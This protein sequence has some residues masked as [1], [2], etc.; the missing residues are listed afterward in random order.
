MAGRDRAQRAALFAAE[1]PVEDLADNRGAEDAAVPLR[2]QAFEQPLGRAG[3]ILGQWR[4]IDALNQPGGLIRVFDLHQQLAQR[5]RIDLDRNGQQRFFRRGD[6]LAFERQRNRQ[7]QVVVGVVAERLFTEKDPLP[8]LADDDDARL[9]DDGHA[10]HALAGPEKAHRV[11]VGGGVPFADGQGLEQVGE[12]S[13]LGDLH[14]PCPLMIGRI[15]RSGMSF[16]KIL[17][18]N[19]TNRQKQ[20]N[21]GQE[22]VLAHPLGPPNMKRSGHGWR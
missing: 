11:E 5:G 15:I 14:G 18:E 6:G 22:W 4:R 9:I 20:A 7:D 1:N 16:R 21:S 19:V 10:R 2:A 3:E 17:A 8:A 13:V 12:A